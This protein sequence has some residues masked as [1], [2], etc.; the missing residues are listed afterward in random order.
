MK[1]L[2][3]LAS[4][5]NY[6]CNNIFSIN[7]GFAPLSL[8]TIAA[9]VPE[10][11]H[12]EIRIID[13]GMQK[14]NYDKLNYDIVGISCCASSSNRAY[15]LAQ[16]WKTRGAYTI[17]GGYHAT[18]CPQ[19][20]SMHCDSV[21]SGF[22]ENIF[23]QV[24]EDIICGNTQKIYH[25]DCMQKLGNTLPRRD[26]IKTIPYWAKNTIYATRGCV[27][28]CKYCSVSNFTKSNYIKRP[29][30]E[31]IN[32]IK[33][34]KFK[35]LF[36]LDSNFTADREY[37][38]ELM[39]ALIP[40]KLKYY[41]DV[42]F[43]IYSDNE[44]M[45]LLRQSGCFEVFIGFETF[46]NNNL[47]TNN[48]NQ[49][50]TDFYENCVKTFHYHNIA[51]TGGFMV[52]MDNDTE[53]NLR[54]LPEYTADLRID[55]IRYTVF[56]PLPGTPL[57]EQ[58]KKENRLLTYNYDY[59]DLM[60]VIHKPLNIDPRKLQEI[61]AWIWSDS[62]TMKRILYRTNLLKHKKE[63]FFANLYFKALGNKISSTL[64]Y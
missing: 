40:L 54:L 22:G 19:E 29:I 55:V 59:Y 32:E 2:F 21:I 20:V 9:S 7:N 56:T 1:I 25:A 3:I 61:F 49:N 63:T 12:A 6:R 34:C 45:E 41:A 64:E 26:L 30:G 5:K 28:K 57:F 4:D 8:T 52:G 46:S 53:E 24:L 27:N 37:A 39:T 17:I 43:D 47:C 38:K 11:Y 31:V 60:H 62:Y 14:V 48:K 23:P 35:K 42:T 58:Y 16:Y 51:I 44:L 15:E 33:S 50:K 36:F 18:L 10:K 13:E